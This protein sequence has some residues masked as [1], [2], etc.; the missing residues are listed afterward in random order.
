M[1]GRIERD[2]R[3]ARAEAGSLNKRLD[4]FD[5]N[6]EVG[7]SNIH[8]SISSLTTDVANKETIL[9]TGKSNIVI[10]DWELGNVSGGDNLVSNTHIRNL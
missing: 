5:A 6:T 7:L 10:S 2:L 3:R 8:N 4:T 1:H 9:S